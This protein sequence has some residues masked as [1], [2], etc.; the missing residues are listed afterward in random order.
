MRRIY[1]PDLDLDGDGWSN[2]AEFRAGTSPALPMSTGI[3]N[4]TLI[5]HPEPVVEMEVVYNGTSDIEGR[6]LVVKAWNEALDPDAL[7]APVATWT[8]TTANEISTAGDNADAQVS[9]KEKYIGRMPTGKRTYY[10]GGAI[11]EGSFKLLL[12]DL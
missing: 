5:E 9:D 10:L 11:K 12:K 3:D 2:Y 1:D 6:T 8:V 4:Y 7:S